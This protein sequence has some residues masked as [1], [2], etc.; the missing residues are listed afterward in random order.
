MNSRPYK[1]Q[2][3]SKDNGNNMSNKYTLT[4]D[5]KGNVAYE[6]ISPVVMVFLIFLVPYALWIIINS[7][8]THSDVLDQVTELIHR[9]DSESTPQS[10]T[11]K[12]VVEDRCPEVAYLINKRGYVL[13]NGKQDLKKFVDIVLACEA[14]Q[15]ITI[16]RK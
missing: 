15:K 11:A 16:M 13:N 7:M 12:D 6:G 2:N 1:Q 4:D 5:I 3:S 8:K 10:F 14:N 9:A